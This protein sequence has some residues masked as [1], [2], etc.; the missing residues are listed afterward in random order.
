MEHVI[1]SD[2]PR[3]RERA[4]A[5]WEREGRPEGQHLQ[6]WEQATREIAEED[7]ALGPE[8]GIQ[9]PDNASARALREAAEHL[10]GANAQSQSEDMHRRPSADPVKVSETGWAGTGT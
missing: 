4:Y 2:D 10:R 5:I 6:H 3:I 1:G 8:A 9:V 7:I